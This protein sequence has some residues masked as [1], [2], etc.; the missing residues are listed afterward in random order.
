MPA[1]KPGKSKQD[2][3]TPPEFLDAVRNRF[4]HLVWDLAASASNA[5]CPDYTDRARNSLIQPWHTYPTGGWL[6][7]NPE[8]D[9][10]AP[11]AEKCAAEMRLGARILLLTPA[12]TGANWLQNHV[13]PNAHIV[14]LGTRMRFVGAKDLYPKDLFL[15]VFAYGLTGR[16]TW[17]WNVPW[18]A[19][20]TAA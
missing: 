4:G 1:Q 15:S 13:V 3:G 20:K 10:I 9:D 16:S 19:I 8:F 17:K 7:L 5:V 6:W 14:E 12:S 2:Y 11:W 18:R